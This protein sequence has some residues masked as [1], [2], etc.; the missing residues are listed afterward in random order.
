MG[1]LETLRI[2]RKTMRVIVRYW[3]EFGGSESTMNVEEIAN[4]AKK[5]DIMSVTPVEE[6]YHIV[7]NDVAKFRFELVTMIENVRYN[8]NEYKDL[9][10][11]QVAE[12]FEHTINAIVNK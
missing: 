9:S 12:K 10:S 1:V 4:F 7:I 2:Q 5:F 3:T 8:I 6:D 11:S